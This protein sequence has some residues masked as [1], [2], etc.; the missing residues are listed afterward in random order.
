MPKS[1]R[2]L[3]GTVVGYV[4][5]ER[6]AGYL[7]ERPRKYR[8]QWYCL[9][10]ACGRHFTTDHCTIV[11]NGVQS[12]GCMK[13][14][15]ASTKLTTHGEASR[16]TPEYRTWNAMKT[17]CFNERDK[18]FVRY[19]AKGITVCDRWLGENGF[20]AFLSDMG[21]RPSARHSIDRFPNQGGNYEPGNCRWATS[22]EQA[23]NRRDNRLL[24]HNGKTEPV[25]Q[26]SDD[27]SLPQAVITGRLKRGWTVA[28]ALDTSYRPG[29]RQSRPED[30]RLLSVGGVT[31]TL[32]EWGRA[33]GIDRTT[34]AARLDRGWSADD[35]VGKP[36]RYMRMSASR[37]AKLVA[38]K[39][40][41][42]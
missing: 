34:L 11:A 10:G 17:R 29:Q 14:A 42:R 25:S 28:Q 8:A 26:W 40:T 20:E 6:F 37:R 38:P 1:L 16:R 4:T 21:R 41:T 5:V 22:E 35:V 13:P 23:R 33:T 12:C 7:T 36:V 15:L 18:D 32:T 31:R 27:T 9:C 19:G 39:S 30:D 2:D 3:T 24:S